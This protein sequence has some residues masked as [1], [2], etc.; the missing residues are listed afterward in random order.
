MPTMQVPA[1]TENAFADLARSHAPALDA[2]QALRAAA[3]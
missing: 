1:P 3:L 2:C